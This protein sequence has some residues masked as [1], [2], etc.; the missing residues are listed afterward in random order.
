[1]TCPQCGAESPEGA[2]FCLHC[3]CLM[4]AEYAERLEREWGISGLSLRV[5]IHT[6]LVVEE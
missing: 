4:P 2:R 6:G 5:G 1:M 3:E